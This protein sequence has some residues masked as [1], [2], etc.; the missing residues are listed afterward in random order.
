MTV[1]AAPADQPERGVFGLRPPPL[2]TPVEDAVAR[3]LER[4]ARAAAEKAGTKAPG[5]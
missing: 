4:L 3:Q 2:H 5:A 1:G